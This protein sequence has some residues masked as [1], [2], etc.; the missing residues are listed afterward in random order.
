MD[1]ALLPLLIAVTALSLGAVVILLVLVFRRPEQAVGDRVRGEVERVNEVVRTEL[2]AGRT[3]HLGA[4]RQTREEIAGAVRELTESLQQRLAE[5]RTTLD[6]R[7]QQ[8][9][10][11]DRAADAQNRAE[12]QNALKDFREV[13][14]R[15]LTESTDSQRERLQAFAQQLTDLAKRNET[16]LEA[17]RTTLETRLTDLQKDNEANSST[18][19]RQWMKSCT[20]P[21]NSVL[22]NPSSWSANGSNRSTAGLGK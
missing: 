4:A 5:L 1:S 13:L 3:E 22:A 14:A 20:K 18:S 11:A 8:M 19:A 21:S 16:G 7:L 12:L 2:Q 17:L 15:R 10:E 9:H 6:S